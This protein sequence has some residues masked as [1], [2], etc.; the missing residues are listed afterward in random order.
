M[1]FNRDYILTIDIRGGRVEI[2][3]P[4]RIV[5]SVDKSDEGGLNKCQI[6]LF[7]LSEQNRFAIVKDAEEAKRIPIN[8][9]VGYQGK[10]ETIYKG[11]IQVGANERQGADLV[12]TITGLDGGTDGLNSFTNRTID[13]G[14]RAINAILLDM[15]NTSVG[16]VNDRP[17]LS[18]PKV[19]V[20]NSLR[21]INDTMGLDESWY[22][23]NEQLFILKD[24]QAVRNF[25]PLVSPAT[26]LIST[27]TRE[28]SKTTFVT[29]IN[30]A[31]KLGSQVNLKS[32]TAPYLDGVYK[33]RSI[34][35]SGDNFGSDWMQSCTCTPANGIELI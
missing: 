3:P 30:P 33:V 28:A 1:R 27:P 5:F 29:L 11:N 17:I 18:R 16:K 35:Y 2:K 9:S 7:N 31:I 20:G 12:S 19:L 14:Q 15:P 26:G 24:G 23:D 6:Q 21:L 34:N 22:I 4:L 32:V 13:G 10:I 25:I 8:L